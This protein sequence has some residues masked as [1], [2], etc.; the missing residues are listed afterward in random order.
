MIIDG[1]ELIL[2]RLAAYVAK[3]ALLGEEIHVVNSDQVVVTGKPDEVL[4]KFKQKRNRGAPLIGPYYPR[5]S[6]RIVKRAIRGM[7]PYKKT[8]GRTAL[9]NVKCYVGIPEGLRNEKM[10]SPAT[11]NVSKTHAKYITIKQI[12]KQLGAKTE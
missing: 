9:S 12:S 2:G 7:L 10:E 11:L 6:D 3:K 4:A 5:T 8:R 1:K